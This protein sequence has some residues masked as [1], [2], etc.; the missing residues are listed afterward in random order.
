MTETWWQ[1]AVV[2]ECHLPS[3][4]DGNGDGVGDLRGLVESL[5]YLRG[6]LG[7]DAIWTGPFYASPLLDQGFD[8]SDYTAVEPVFGTMEIF[9]D[10]LAQAHA[11]GV[12]ILVDY[13][14]NHTSDQHPW[15]LES[16]SSRTDPRRDWYIWRDGRPDASPPN[17]WTSE[18]GGSVWER[19][20]HTGQYYLHSH[21]VEQ[22]DLNWRNPE[23]R[24]ALFDVLR[25]WLDRGVDGVR[26][27]VAHMLM[28]DPQLRDNPPASVAGGNPFDLQHPDFGTQ[29]HVHDRR[30][31]DTFAAL[32]EIRQVVE[33]YPAAVT[34]AEIEAME[35]ADWAAYYGLDLDGM[36][37]PFPFRLL[38]TP[39]VAAA[40][41]AELCGLYAALPAGAWPIVALGNHDRSRLAT[42][43]GKPQARVAAML[44]LTLAAT[45]C[46]LYGDELGMVDQPVPPE[47]QRDFFA[48]SAG[49][50]SR[51]P[52]R[53]PM[54]WNDDPGTGF[55]TAAEADLWLPVAHDAESVNVQAQL[56]DPASFLSLY[57][58]LLAL[59]NER[60]ALRGGDIE[61][62]ASS[63]AGD[64]VLAY[65]R[66]DQEERLLVVLNLT[67]QPRVL[68]GSVAGTTLLSTGDRQ[69]GDQTGPVIDLAPDEGLL[70]DITRGGT[71]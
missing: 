2:Y 69:P 33:D 61:F 53:T 15:F 31:P 35:W 13:I 4:K 8:V 28:K 63:A 20:E 5:D 44:L 29:L 65:E 9:D 23:V 38:E 19:D 27:D 42:R 55:S 48:R 64:G 56:R 11:R 32:A 68:P 22:P 17:N 3:F 49:G 52:V 70:V 62:G 43:L 41:R 46:L 40:L 6:T 1:G 54:P 18:A 36:H 45:P 57:R 26:I 39:W 66:R 59:R 10:L 14:P 30:H 47:R 21:L 71:P 37:L 24:T 60:P 58:R 34:I 12:R 67:D 25:F 51:D 16:R 7:I 50:I